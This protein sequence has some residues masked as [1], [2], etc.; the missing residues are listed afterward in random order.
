MEILI[1][2]CFKKESS[3]PP[4][5]NFTAVF[6]PKKCR[7][8][9]VRASR[10]RNEAA[11]ALQQARRCMTAAAP[12]GPRKALTA[13]LF[14]QKQGEKV[15]HLATNTRQPAI[16]QHVRLARAKLA[17]LKIKIPRP[18]ILE[19][20]KPFVHIFPN[21]TVT[22]HFFGTIGHR[23]IRQDAA[24][25]WQTSAMQNSKFTFFIWH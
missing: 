16:R 8:L 7:G 21:F 13:E 22:S 23:R 1:F 25:Q 4:F 2:A 20:C 9:A 12:S 18:E 11:V 6:R 3:R 10:G 15:A 24:Q 17:N 19:F 14:R 5:C